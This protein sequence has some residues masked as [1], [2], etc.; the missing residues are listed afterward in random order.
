MKF[1][2]IFLSLLICAPAM[3]ATNPCK[4]TAAKTIVS[5][6]GGFFYRDGNRIR[7]IEDISCRKNLSKN[8][9]PYVYCEAIAGG[10]NVGDV[11]FGVNL[12][13]N[14]TRAAAFVIGEE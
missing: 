4:A 13:A 9:R 2:T 6:F 12:N 1:T 7:E 14:C 5:R 8:R 10:D 11:T 3:A